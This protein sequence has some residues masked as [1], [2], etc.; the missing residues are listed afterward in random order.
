[1]ALVLCAPVATHAQ[2]NEPTPALLDTTIAAGEADAQIPVKRGL[3][4]HNEWD[5]GW[6]TFRIGYGFLVD[7]MT[8]VQDDAAKQQTPA[9]ATSACATFA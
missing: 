8:V 1:M 2:S 7:F 9:E 5:F 4:K 6:T 3:A